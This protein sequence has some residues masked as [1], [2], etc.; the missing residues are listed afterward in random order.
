MIL[1]LLIEVVVIDGVGLV[2]CFFNIVLLLLLLMSF[3]LL[4][5]NFVYVFFDMFLVIDVVIG[6]GL[7]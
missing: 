3:F 5:V 1:C 2:W 7:V 6:G 4:V